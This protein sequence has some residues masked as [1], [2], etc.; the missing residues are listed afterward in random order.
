MFGGWGIF[1]EATMFAIVASERLYLKADDQTEARFTAAGL[2][3][4]TYHRQG[5]TVALSYREAPP[6]SLDD[7]AV[8]RDWARLALE[9]AARVPRRKARRRPWPKSL[10]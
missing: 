4:F 7:P 8:L 5:R 10:P 1:H 9:A 3:P 6:E 2:A